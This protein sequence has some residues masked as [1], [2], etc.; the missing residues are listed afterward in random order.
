[1][2]GFDRIFRAAMAQLHLT[3]TAAFSA[4]LALS[5]HRHAHYPFQG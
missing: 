2:H 1:V 3:S 4:R 5:R